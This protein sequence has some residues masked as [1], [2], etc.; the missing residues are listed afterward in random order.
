MMENHDAGEKQECQSM[1]NDWRSERMSMIIIE[2]DG[3]PAGNRNGLPYREHFIQIEV[4]SGRLCVHMVGVLGNCYGKDTGKT[5]M[6]KYLLILF[7]V[8]CFLS[9]CSN[10]KGI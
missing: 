1:D 9:G 4:V 8:S 3:I 7:L 6:K 5:V 2:G 10:K